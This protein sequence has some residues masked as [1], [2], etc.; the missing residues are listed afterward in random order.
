MAVGEV[1]E[2]YGVHR[3]SVHE[4]V[5]RYRSG[6]LGALTDRP[7]RPN[8]PPWQVTAEIEALICSYA[9]HITL[10]SLAA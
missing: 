2:R 5:R 7:H 1:A 9:V 6:G 4:W 3:N 8:D 10:G